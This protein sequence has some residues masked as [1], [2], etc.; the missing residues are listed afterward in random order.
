MLIVRYEGVI[1]LLWQI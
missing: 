1:G